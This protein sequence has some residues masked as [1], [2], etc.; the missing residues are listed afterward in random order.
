MGACLRVMAPFLRAFEDSPF[1]RR[2]G[3]PGVC[4][5]ALGNPHDM[6]LQGF[7]DSLQRMSVPENKDWFAYKMSEPESRRVVMRTLRNLRGMPF[8]EEDIFLTNGGFAALAVALNTVVDRGDEV[9]FVSPPWFFYEP[10]IVAAGATPVRVKIDQ[11]SF[12]LDLEVI[13][14]ATSERTRAIIVNSPHNPTG[15]IY[16][17]ETL[18][19]LAEILSDRSRS[20]GR[21]VYLLSDEAYS[22]IVY[23]G[24]DYPSPTAFYPHTFLIY[25]Y[26]KTLLAP[27]QR[28]GYIALPPTMPERELLRPAVTACQFLTGF[29][30]P[31]ALLQHAL[32]EL[33]Q[34][35]IDVGH[36]QERRDRLLWALRNIGYEVGTP[37]GTFYLMVRSPMDD[38]WEFVEILGQHDILA[39]P[40]SVVEMP[41]YFRLSLTANDEMIERAIPRFGAAWNEAMSRQRE[42]A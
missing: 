42:A 39:L 34:L 14:A 15:K 16:P 33:E 28:I 24:R 40:G 25:T 7:V 5:F 13:E 29:A 26:G 1:A 9:I 4:D 3:E 18:K 27:G 10:M 41:G 17:P 30:F 31:N 6:P 11:Q 20:S 35:S 21:P 19:G 36:L 2:A 38:D 22:H 23:D 37:E 8:E 12:D 32:P